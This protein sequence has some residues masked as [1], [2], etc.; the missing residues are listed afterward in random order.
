[1]T[2]KVLV[3]VLL[4]SVVRVAGGEAA[5]LCQ[6]KSG[7]VV[8]RSACK[9][10]EMPVNLAA[11]G[12]VSAYEVVTAGPY[13]GGGQLTVTCPGTKKVLGGG[14]SDDFTTAQFTAIRP[15][16]DGTQWICGF[17]GS[18]FS[19]NAYAVCADAQ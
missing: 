17:N 7:A 10:K 2:G 9:K 8:V 12:A 16:T 6:K 1:M 19:I 11:F 18:G 3:A 15:A 5:V 13:A 14:C 4:L